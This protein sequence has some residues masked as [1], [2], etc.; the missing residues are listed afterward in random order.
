VEADAEGWAP[1]WRCPVLFSDDSARFAAVEALSE[2][3]AALAA[4][5][6]E[7][8]GRVD[9]AA[10]AAAAAAREHAR[11]AKHAATRQ[12]AAGGAAA[13]QTAADADARARAVRRAGADAEGAPPAV[14]QARFG[15][16]RAAS[17]AAVEAALRA[18]DPGVIGALAQLVT[19]DDERLG[20]VASYA[21]RALLG[22][23][24]VEDTA[25]RARLAAA[26]AS[27][28]YPMPDVVALT[29]LATYRGP[30]SGEVPGFRGAGE[31]ARALAR[32]ACACADRPLPQPLPHQRA[33]ADPAPGGPGPEDWPA[34]C[35]GYLANL[36]RP[37]RKGHRAS[38]VFGLL[39]G[40]IVFETMED[41][42]A[43]REHVTQRLRQPCP[44]L[45]TLDMGRLTSRGVIAGAS[46]RPPPLEKADY[47]IGSNPEGGAGGAAD[48]ARQA[49]AMAELADAL[50]AAEAAEAAAAEAAAEAEGE[51]E[52]CR[53]PLEEAEEALRE[54][55]AVLAQQ[56]AG[57]AGGGGGKAPGS[58]SKRGRGRQA[59]AEAGQP[60]AAP[61]DEEE[62]A[63]AEAAPKAKPKKR[64]LAKG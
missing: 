32:A 4:Q 47:A 25:C 34:G 10:A 26:L 16:P 12:R 29:H 28:K 30:K 45:L 9:A 57:G 52:R 31:L 63:P 21:T 17:T 49:E 53:G 61:A 3:R 19:V 62:E 43:Y 14:R 35:L 51:E 42:C 55:D 5:R 54:V 60:E 36:V 11:L 40:V 39:S 56:G 64:R 13:P 59:Q 8:A 15:P 22:V 1:C 20:R 18:G 41:A 50:R 23:L 37:V 38:V 33:G 27:T 24:V 7:L 46:F 44:D 48:A 58:G 2:R 6:A